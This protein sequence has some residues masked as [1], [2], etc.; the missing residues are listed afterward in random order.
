MRARVAAG[1]APAPASE[2][3]ASTAKVRT[4]W[5]SASR[6]TTCGAEGL[7]WAEGEAGR[8]GEEG[9]R[10]WGY[11]RAGGGSEHRS[12]SRRTNA[13]QASREVRWGGGGGGYT[14]HVEGMVEGAVEGEGLL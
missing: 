12:A 5:S 14:L 7:K 6:R 4:A 9:Q 10:A 8:R 3:K 2:L 13:G 11:Q 1:K